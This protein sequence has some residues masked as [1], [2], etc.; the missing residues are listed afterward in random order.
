MPG[1]AARQIRGEV[2]REDRCR[3]NGVDP[4]LGARIRREMRAVARGVERRMRGGTEVPVHHH[5]ALMGVEPGLAQPA[6]RRRTRRPDGDIRRHMP[7]ALQQQRIGPHLRGRVVLD[8]L[9]TPAGQCAHQMPPRRPRDGGQHP[10]AID[11]RDA[12]I[13]SRLL[14]TMGAGHGDLGPRHAAT[15]DG[16]PHRARSRRHLRPARGETV[17]R[18]GGDA[19]LGESP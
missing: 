5:E 2:M 7:P 10:A 17:E 3:A 15:D 8:D 14:Q 4:G 12:T 11:E 13:P 9:D 6:L 18:L 16:D 19:V 1:A